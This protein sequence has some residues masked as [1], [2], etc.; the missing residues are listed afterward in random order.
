MRIT[1]IFRPYVPVEEK[2]IDDARFIKENTG[3]DIIFLRDSNGELWHEAQY[4]FSNETLKIAFDENGVIIMYSEDATLLNPVNCAV[5]EVNKKNVPAQLDE[6]QGWI[7]R[8]GK[9]I[10]RVYTN[11]EYIAQ[12]EILKQEL[13]ATA[14]STIAPLQD[15][16]EIDEATDAEVSLLKEWKKYRVLLN[17][18]DTSIAPDIVWPEVPD[19]VA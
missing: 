9:I 12:A 16:V 18:V 7:Y 4:Q 2:L 6:S 13:M 1:G 10:P 3:M 15:A 8:G 19:N 11:E 5:A 17:R 14:F